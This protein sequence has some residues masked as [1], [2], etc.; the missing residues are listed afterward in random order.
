MIA[1]PDKIR[2]RDPPLV[3]RRPSPIGRRYL[4]EALRRLPIPIPACLRRNSITVR[5]AWSQIDPNPTRP[6]LQSGLV[7]TRNADLNFPHKRDPGRTSD[8]PKNGPAAPKRF[9]LRRR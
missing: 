1:A 4:T 2:T 8:R 9:D 3:R 5:S 7:V 6:A